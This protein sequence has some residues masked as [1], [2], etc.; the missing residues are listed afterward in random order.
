MSTIPPNIAHSMVLEDLYLKLVNGNRDHSKFG[1]SHT[2][3]H[4]LLNKKYIE[5]LIKIYKAECRVCSNK[6]LNLYF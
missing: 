3:K 5:K 6:N 2:I 1:I 4:E